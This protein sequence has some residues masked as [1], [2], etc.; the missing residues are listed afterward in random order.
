MGWHAMTGE[1]ICDVTSLVTQGLTGRLR[2]GHRHHQ[3]WRAGTGPHTSLSQAKYPDQT[4]QIHN[5]PTP[6]ILSYLSS[7]QFDLSSQSHNR[8]SLQKRQLV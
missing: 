6:S 5:C 1:S 3:E 7:Q 4:N 8:L 2:G